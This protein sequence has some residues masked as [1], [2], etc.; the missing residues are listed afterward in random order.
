ME[1]PAPPPKHVRRNIDLADAS[2]SRA[3][4]AVGFGW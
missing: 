1:A 4:W 3:F 2:G